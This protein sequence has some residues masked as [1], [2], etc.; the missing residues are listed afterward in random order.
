MIG[1]MGLLSSFGLGLTLLMPGRRVFVLEGDGS[2]LMSLGTL[3]LIAVESP[4]NLVH[5]IL[6][7]EAY[8]STGSQP[9]ISSRVDLAEIAKSSGY[10]HVSRVDDIEGLEGSLA[11]CKGNPGPH[12][13]LVKAAIAPV[14]GIPRVS[15]TPTEIRD[16]FSSSIHR[17]GKAE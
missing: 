14:P 5:V 16:R 1:S 9:S 3:P 7:N 10:K 13:I 15:H 2:A 17:E 11:E 6:D 4:P 8:E 12:L